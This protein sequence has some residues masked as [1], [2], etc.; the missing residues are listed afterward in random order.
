MT[1]ASRLPH[2]LRCRL[3][4]L[5]ADRRGLALVEFAITLPVLLILYLGGFQ[6]EDGIACKRKVTVATRAVADLV[7]QNLS[8]S[9]TAVEIDADMAAATQV[10]V[11]Y[12]IANAVVRVTQVMT[13]SKGKTTVQWSR[14]LNATAYKAGA[15][16]T[17]P[18]AMRIQGTYFLF[19]EVTYA[20]KL[21]SFGSGTSM[22]LSDSLYM[23]P[24]NSSQ[25]TCSDC[26]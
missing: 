26:S 18:T 9:T 12:P 1:I 8:G 10:L 25:I 20:Y 7:A 15:T 21:P 11:P 22:T 16:A 19:A 13:D 24:R 2:R 4:T 3:R 23:L 17:I 5:V 14:A 6:L